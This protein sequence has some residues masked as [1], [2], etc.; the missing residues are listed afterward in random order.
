MRVQK[1][2]STIEI[3]AEGL[4][5]RDIKVILTPDGRGMKEK[6]EALNRIIDKVRGSGASI[7]EK[8]N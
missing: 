1:N 3:N 7:L 8:C 4:D 5:E 2:G 6:A